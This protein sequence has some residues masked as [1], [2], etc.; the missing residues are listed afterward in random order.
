MLQYLKKCNLDISICRIRMN[1]NV[2]LYH[3]PRESSNIVKCLV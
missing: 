2:H 1:P 3:A